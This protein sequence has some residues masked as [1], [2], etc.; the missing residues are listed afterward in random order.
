VSASVG[1]RI[2]VL[3]RVLLVLALLPLAL[4]PADMAD[5]HM[6]FAAFV[7]VKVAADGGPCGPDAD[8]GGAH[9]VCGPSVSCFAGV[10]T[11]PPV[12][13][14]DEMAL[15][16]AVRADVAPAETGP[17]PLFHPPKHSIVA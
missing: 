16:P 14:P 15:P 6:D 4:S 13:Q 10:F 17:P 7:A 11:G 12:I 5:A 9:A 3:I 1:T 8:H 2:G